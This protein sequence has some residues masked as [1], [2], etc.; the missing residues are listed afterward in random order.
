MIGVLLGLRLSGKK[1]AP[2]LS[3]KKMTRT[4]TERASSQIVVHGCATLTAGV[5]FLNVV[6][7]LLS[8]DGASCCR[9]AVL[10]EQLSQQSV[11]LAEQENKL[12]KLDASMQTILA[13]CESINTRL[14]PAP[15]ED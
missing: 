8:C 3:G 4:Q 7:P 1:M 15:T 10:K 11:T 14:P 2:R 9:L 5:S 12:S 6:F 13:L